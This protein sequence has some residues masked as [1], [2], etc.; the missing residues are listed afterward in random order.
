MKITLLQVKESIKPLTKLADVKLPTKIAYRISRLKSKLIPEAKLFKEEEYKLVKE[1]GVCIDK[2]T[3][4]WEVKEEK[5]PEFFKKM[6]EMEAEEIEID[7]EPL[8]LESLGNIELEASI[9]PDW[10]FVE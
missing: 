5:K 7:F 8:K 10:A 3:D 9:I 1:L 6:N 4:T 2:K